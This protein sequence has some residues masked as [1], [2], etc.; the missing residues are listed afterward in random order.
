MSGDR[1]AGKFKV[2]RRGFDES[3]PEDTVRLHGCGP[4]PNMF[5]DVKR[6]RFG[7]RVLVFHIFLPFFS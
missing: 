3:D 7:D 5:S 6:P 4:L 1:K 2:L